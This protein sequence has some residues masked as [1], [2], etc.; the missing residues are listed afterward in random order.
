MI[1]PVRGSATRAAARPAARRTVHPVV[2]LYLNSPARLAG[3]SLG[4][5]IGLPG[6]DNNGRHAMAHGPDLRRFSMGTEED[7]LSDHRRRRRRRG[8]PA[9]TDR[10]ERHGD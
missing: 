4:T 3:G 6:S 7:D 1:S 10:T 8:L 9:G 5:W 2:A